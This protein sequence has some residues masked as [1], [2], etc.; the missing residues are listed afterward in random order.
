MFSNLWMWLDGKKAYIGGVATILT[1]LGQIGLSYYS[2]Q[3]FSLE[4][5]HTI[6]AGWALI[7]GKSALAKI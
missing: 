7:A 3:G 4:G 2:N 1:G 6:L 5:W